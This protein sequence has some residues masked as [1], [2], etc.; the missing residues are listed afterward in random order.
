MLT[1]SKQPG[2]SNQRWRAALR[3]F[4][5]VAAIA[6][7]I[8]FLRRS[9]LGQRLTSLAEVRAWVGSFTPYDKPAFILIYAIGALFLPGTVL[10][11]T[12]AI[13]F[14]VWWGTLLVWCGAVLG[15]LAP[16]WIARLIGRPAVEAL[17]SGGQASFQRFD[18]WL[19]RRGFVGLLLVRFLPIFPFWLVNYG[20][21]LVGIRFR[22]YVAA[23]AIGILPGTFVY[24]YLFA[25]IGET[26]LQTGFR[27]E[28][29]RDPNLLAPIAVFAL[30][31]LMGRWFASRLQ[32]S[33]EEKPL[34]PP[35]PSP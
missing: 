3:L 21:G 17:V 12:G 31:L 25:T 1:F 26:F 33:P 23:T 14:G 19:G 15:S 35:P 20:S 6:L 10:S 13:L 34:R 7:A 28:H 30:F 18:E 27:W 8:C 5:I 11:F 4:L 9:P 32:E 24:Q 22:D 2:M 29:F 16:F